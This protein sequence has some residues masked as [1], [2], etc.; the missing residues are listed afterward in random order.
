M[1]VQFFHA[2][3]TTTHTYIMNDKHLLFQ[4]LEEM[5]KL[6]QELDSMS[7]CKEETVQY[8]KCAESRLEMRNQRPT[9][10]KT[11]D[12]P[13]MGLFEEVLKL[14][15]TLQQLDSRIADSK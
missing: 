15:E 13:Q 4:I 14:K 1:E 8:L 5:E 10:E 11:N 3:T 12:P 6:N 9:A 7:K 2:I